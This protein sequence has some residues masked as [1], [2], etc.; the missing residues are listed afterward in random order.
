MEK[1]TKMQLLKRELSET[2][3]DLDKYIA[4]LE[5]KLGDEIILWEKQNENLLQSNDE[6]KGA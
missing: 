3:S 4:F 5:D 2:L 1:L 6:Q